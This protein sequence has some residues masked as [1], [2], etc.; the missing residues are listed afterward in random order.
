MIMAHE[1]GFL[2]SGIF[3]WIA[4]SRRSPGPASLSEGA[5]IRFYCIGKIL[6]K[7]TA[8]Q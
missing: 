3:A 1:M 2:S 8:P 7:L 6:Q 5:P 4:G